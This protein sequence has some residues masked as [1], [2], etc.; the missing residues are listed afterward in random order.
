MKTYKLLIMM[1][2]FIGSVT[3]TSAQK[4]GYVNTQDLLG[5]LPE[6]KEAE[7]TLETF[8]TQ[9]EKQYQQRIKTLQ[10]KYQELQR[11]QDNGELSPK[12]LEIEAAKLKEQEAALGQFNQDSQKKIMDKTNTLLGP[13]QEKIRVAIKQVAD[14]GGY[15]YIFD[16][17]LGVIL[18]ADE[19]T[20][21]GQL[22]KAK[23]NM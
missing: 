1:A 16:Y 8:K 18:Y 10:T 11:Q 22:V 4:F 19:S 6:V 3:I 7:S 21:V 12:Q 15:A 2:L 5:E 20:D 9:L 14:E 13:I 23:L 17:S